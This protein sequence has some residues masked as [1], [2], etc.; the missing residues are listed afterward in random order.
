M[1]GLNEDG[2]VPSLEEMTVPAVRSV[3]ELRIHAVHLTH[4][5]RKISVRRLNEEVI[6]VVHQ[7][8]GMADPIVTFINVLEGIQKIEAVLVGFE[9]RLSLVASGGNMIHSASIFDS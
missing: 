1:R 5:E 2:L 6:V 7:T 3:K 4:A 9:D 8:A